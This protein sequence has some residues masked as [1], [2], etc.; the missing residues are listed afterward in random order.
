M[1]RATAVAAV[2]DSSVVFG[3]PALTKSEE[4]RKVIRDW[5]NSVMVERKELVSQ[6]KILKDSLD[7]AEASGGDAKERLEKVKV[8]LQRAYATLAKLK[9]ENARLVTQAAH[10]APRRSRSRSVSPRNNAAAFIAL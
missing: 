6:I 5:M 2:A 7:A 4:E 9:E 3:A 8:K 1:K 10:T